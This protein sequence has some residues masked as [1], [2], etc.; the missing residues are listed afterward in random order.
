M[1]DASDFRSPRSHCLHP[2]RGRILTSVGSFPSGNGRAFE[3]VA[4]TRLQPDPTG[5]AEFD[6]PSLNVFGDACEL[7]W[8]QA[9]PSLAEV[10]FKTL[11]LPG[12][13]L[14]YVS[15]V[16]V[17]RPVDQV[18]S[19]NELLS[20]AGDEINSENSFGGD[21]YDEAYIGPIGSGGY[22]IIETHNPMPWKIDFRSVSPAIT[23]TI[24]R[25]QAIPD[26]GDRA[27]PPGHAFVGPETLDAAQLAA[28]RRPATSLRPPFPLYRFVF[29]SPGPE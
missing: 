5:P 4:D 15:A 11:R 12:R 25:W 28:I 8:R 21:R 26:P 9:F 2:A 7:I 23:G 1:K 14:L 18:L 27:A 24:Y 10:G 19:E 22:G 17:F 29:D 20:S 3:V 13:T 6:D 16:S